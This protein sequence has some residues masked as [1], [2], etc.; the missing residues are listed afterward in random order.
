MVLGRPEIAILGA[1]G[2][3]NID[4]LRSAPKR[5]IEN[6]PLLLDSPQDPL[7][8]ELT[9]TYSRVSMR[10]WGRQEIV[11]FGGS[12]GLGGSETPSNRGA[13]SQPT[14]Y[15]FRTAGAAG[16]SRKSTISERLQNHV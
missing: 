5:C 6:P 8:P 14:I 3:P 7:L 11:D 10:L 9:T 2:T 16:T 4:D 1:A 12:D 13:A 15:I